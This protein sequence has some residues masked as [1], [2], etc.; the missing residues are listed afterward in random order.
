MPASDAKLFMMKGGNG[1]QVVRIRFGEG[2]LLRMYNVYMR[3]KGEVLKLKGIHHTGSD[4]ATPTTSSVRFPGKGQTSRYQNTE[5]AREKWQ[6]MSNHSRNG[7]ALS[8]S[9]SQDSNYLSLL[10]C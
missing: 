10:E 6:R 1:R 3:R 2:V 9:D 5:V 8:S 7:V 4:L